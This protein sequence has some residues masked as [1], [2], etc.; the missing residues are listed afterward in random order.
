MIRLPEFYEFYQLG[1]KD[2]PIALSSLHGS[3]S[4]DLLDRV[5]ELCPDEKTEEGELEDEMIRV[6]VIGKPN[7]G[8]SSIINR[9]LGN[10]RLIVSEMAGTT[11]DAIDSEVENEY[12]KYVF[13]DTAGI[14]RQSKVEDPIEKYSVL[15]AKLAVDRADVCVIMIDAEQ[16]IT[17]QDERIAGIAHEAGK[18]SVICINKWDLIE[19]DNNTVREFTEKIYKALSYMTYAEV[20]FLSAKTGQRVSRIFEM[21]NKAYEQIQTPY[22]NRQCSMIY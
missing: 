7:A 1:F 10:D 11:R 13:I 16:G 2:D 8:K 22:Y 12:G 4:G 17:E 9:I 19:K 15:R 21:I 14:R 5:L 6:A 18:P 20:I 3:G